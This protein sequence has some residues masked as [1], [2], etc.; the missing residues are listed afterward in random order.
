MTH[1]EE[2]AA[3]LVRHQSDVQRLSDAFVS[4]LSEQIAHHDADKWDYLAHHVPDWRER[5]IRASRHHLCDR[6]GV[7]DDVNLV[8]V[9]EFVLDI[10]AAGMA[11]RGKVY[12][13]RL[14]N[15]VLE[16]ALH[17]T[18]ALLTTHVQENELCVASRCGYR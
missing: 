8:D 3:G 10:V 6:D 4:L 12:P 16:Q 1:I 18:V 9:I 5:H 11:N 17:N 7:P 14:P 2:L 15:G 13:P